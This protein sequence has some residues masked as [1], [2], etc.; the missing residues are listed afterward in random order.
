[1][2][3]FDYQ[4]AACDAIDEDYVPSYNTPPPPC[5]ACGSI[6]RAKIWAGKGALMIPDTV[7]GG[8]IIEN[9][10]RK[11]MRFDSKS[12]Y[13]AALLA[14]GLTNDGFKHVGEQGSDKGAKIWN[15]N[16]RR[17][18]VRSTRWI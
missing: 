1:M 8:F 16:T 18:E 11:P 5:H 7:P 13:K 14:R 10:D 9:I 15:P 3:V 4:C 17:H 6:E 2:P 12:E